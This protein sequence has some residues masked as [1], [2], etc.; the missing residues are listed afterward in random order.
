MMDLEDLNNYRDIVN[1]VVSNVLR[2]DKRSMTIMENTPICNLKVIRRSA[3]DI[4]DPNP[5]I[6]VMENNSRKYPISIDSRRAN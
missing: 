4:R 5:I 3:K 1:L 2:I 6:S